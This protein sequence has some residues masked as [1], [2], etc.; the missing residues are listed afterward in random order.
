MRPSLDAL[1]T[2]SFSRLAEPLASLRA[3][4]TDSVKLMVAR[5]AALQAAVETYT[6]AVRMDAE[7][8]T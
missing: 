6:D 5:S 4:L 8:Y 2:E 3:E 1:L 7:Y